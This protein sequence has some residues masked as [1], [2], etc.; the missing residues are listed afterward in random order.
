MALTGA[1]LRGVCVGCAALWIGGIPDYIALRGGECNDG[2]AEELT[3]LLAPFGKLEYVKGRYKPPGAQASRLEAWMGGSWGLV[4]FA[5]KAACAKAKEAGVRVPIRAHSAA[6]AEAPSGYLM[7]R[8]IDK[9]LADNSP[10]GRL[11]AEQNVKQMERALSQ[12]RQFV[13]LMQYFAVFFVC[14]QSRPA[15]LALCSAGLLVHAWI[16][17]SSIVQLCAAVSE[18]PSFSSQINAKTGE[19]AAQGRP[20]GRC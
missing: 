1:C 9:R 11:A 8:Y 12:Y 3:S 2:I 7:V 16:A 20:R 13:R 5:T 17:G 18:G 19:G 15:V 6:G 10:I 4:T 14:K